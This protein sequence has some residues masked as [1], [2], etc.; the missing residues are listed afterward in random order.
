MNCAGDCKINKH[1]VSNM[2]AEAV[3]I[4]GDCASIGSLQSF[5]DLDMQAFKDNFLQGRDKPPPDFP[6]PVERLY[7]HMRR[8]RLLTQD[9]RLRHT[10]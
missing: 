8:D 4:Q 5:I 3:S 7:I 9:G 1:F 6:I 10:L 2:R